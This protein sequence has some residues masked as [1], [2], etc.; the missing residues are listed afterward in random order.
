MGSQF[1]GAEEIP[2]NPFCNQEFRQDS[3]AL[4]DWKGNNPCAISWGVLY[5]IA[6][7]PSWRTTRYSH[8]HCAKSKTSA[9][10]ST[11]RPPTSRQKPFDAKTLREAIGRA[12]KS[13]EDIDI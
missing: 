5:R 12:V 4:G 8:S 2:Y 7:R 3:G 13:R 1:S 10:K 6:S 9:A 11:L